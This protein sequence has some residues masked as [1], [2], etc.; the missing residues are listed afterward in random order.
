MT[1]VQTTDKP[2]AD[3]R[4]GEL[5]QRLRLAIDGASIRAFAAKAGIAEGTL[6]NLIGGGIPRLDNV[7]RIAGAA[8]VSAA[9]LATGEGQMRPEREDVRTPWRHQASAFREV[10]ERAEELARREETL[11]LPPSRILQNPKLM[12]IKQQLESIPPNDRLHS[13]ADWLLVHA[14]GSEPTAGWRDI[15]KLSIP[16]HLRRAGEILALLEEGMGYSPPPQWREMIRGLIFSHGLDEA[17]AALLL[18][19]LQLELEKRE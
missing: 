7:L 6:R 18:E 9:W 17:G 16:A 1:D 12:R 11:P 10:I 19:R 15:H 3:P 5:P 2:I 8:G 13:H 14:F 4:I